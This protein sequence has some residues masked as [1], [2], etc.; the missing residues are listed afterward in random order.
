[1]IYTGRFSVSYPQNGGVS[2]FLKFLVPLILLLI[3][4]QSLCKNRA[5]VTRCHL[6]AAI[7]SILHHFFCSLRLFRRYRIYTLN[8]HL[9]ILMA[10]AVSFYF[11]LA[12]HAVK[13]FFRISSKMA[14]VISVYSVTATECFKCCKILCHIRVTANKSVGRFVA[15]FLLFR[16]EQ[17]NKCFLQ[18][19]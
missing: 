13:L 8:L 9:K 18:A 1:M 11:F 5:L 3:E 2:H 16:N 6:V 10:V 19:A 17:K 4:F 15:V 12:L 7:Q 14:M